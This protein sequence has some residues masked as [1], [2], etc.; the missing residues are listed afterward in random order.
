MNDF[1]LLLKSQEI[2]KNNHLSIN[3]RYKNESLSIKRENY[4]QATTLIKRNKIIHNIDK[5]KS[6]YG[7]FTNSLN[8]KLTFHKIQMLKNKY[9]S[10][11]I[12]SNNNFNISND[13]KFSINN[14][15]INK[16][17]FRSSSLQFVKEN[18]IIFNNFYKTLKNKKS[19]N[20][21]EIINKHKDILSQQRKM[22]EKLLIS[23]NE[24]VINS[25]NDTNKSQKFGQKF[26]Y[27]KNTREEYIIIDKKLKNLLKNDAFNKTKK[28]EFN[29]IF[30]ISKKINMLNE[31]KKD[32][33][34]LSK[35]SFEDTSLTPKDTG[36]FFS[37]K[38]SD[39]F[40][41]K[42]ERKLNLFYEV[43]NEKNEYIDNENDI[44]KPI[45]IKSLPKPKLDVPNYLN[46]YSN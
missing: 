29:A 27:L 44:I 17:L 4:N 11:N 37:A 46:F 40:N 18:N 31:L 13:E 43:F 26:K 21:Y 24:K 7:F 25:N 12:N 19:T 10:N 30:P 22:K 15:K 35:K 38:K 1:K 32:I 45:L 16:N 3:D 20:I 2:S 28:R 9:L 6:K 23:K 34:N 33:K 41:N 39:N 14:N 42:S 8:Q 5:I 36:P